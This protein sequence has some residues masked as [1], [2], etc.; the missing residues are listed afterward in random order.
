MEYRLSDLR[1]FCHGLNWLGVDDWELTRFPASARARVPPEV[2]ERATRPA[3]A[4]LRFRAETT[5]LGLELEY[6]P[7]PV[8]ERFSRVGQ[9]GWD[10]YVDG[11]YRDSF[12]PT[13]PEGYNLLWVETD[14]APHE[15]EV[16]LPTYAPVQFRSLGLE[17]RLAPARPLRE[18]RPVVVYGSSITQ[19]A[20]ASRPGLAFPAQLARTLDAEV[21]NF[22][23]SG[24][25]KGEAAVA[26]LLATVESPSCY[27][28]DWGINL[29]A[30]EEVDWIDARYP[31][32][33]EILRA[34]HPT[35]PLVFVGTAATGI[36]RWDETVARN[37]DRIR[38]TIRR[39]HDELLARDAAEAARVRYLDGREVIGPG[40]MDCTVDG[41]HYND[42]G[43]R[44]YARALAP[45]I[46]DL[47]ALAP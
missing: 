28:L 23:F 6:G 19:G 44:R 13:Q 38:A 31:R 26:A 37:L 41:V 33:V 11:T 24:W 21:Y 34:E 27:V 43:F 29:M 3:G 22:G 9:Y 42:W 39:T 17:G 4:R 20:F 2:W 45:V 8:Y 32:F 30:P 14:P 18:P 16:Y 46:R 36:E 7:A 10:V 1:A 25:G 47:L 35:V 15:Y 5:Y 40:D 12:V